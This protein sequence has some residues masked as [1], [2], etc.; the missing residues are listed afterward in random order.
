[1]W[2]TQIAGKYIPCEYSTEIDLDE[3]NIRYL[4]YADSETIK[5]NHLHID[6]LRTLVGTTLPLY[7][8]HIKSGI[9]YN[10]GWYQLRSIQRIDRDLS[11]INLKEVDAIP[12]IDINKPDPVRKRTL[13]DRII[14]FIKFKIK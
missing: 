8:V 9:K 11:K 13:Q 3:I 1:M 4:N 7:H 12:P 6:H 2:R 5:E 10:L 14:D